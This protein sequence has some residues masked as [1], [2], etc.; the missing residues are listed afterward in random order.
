[1]VHCIGVWKAALTLITG[2]RD[3]M[4][5]DIRLECRRTSEGFIIEI[6]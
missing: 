1:M 2:T 5:F 6:V 4:R 3:K